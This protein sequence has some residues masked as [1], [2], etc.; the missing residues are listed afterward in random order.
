MAGINE[1][2]IPGLAGR[3]LIRFR[4]KEGAP[5]TLPLPIGGGRLPRATLSNGFRLPRGWSGPLLTPTTQPP[6]RRQDTG[7]LRTGAPAGGPPE[8]GGARRR[9]PESPPVA[10]ALA[11]PTGGAEARSEPAAGPGLLG[12]AVRPSRRSPKRPPAPGHR[13]ARASRPTQQPRP[14]PPREYGPAPAR[15]ST[16]RTALTSPRGP[17]AGGSNGPGTRGL[18]R[19]QWPDSP[20]RQRPCCRWRNSGG[21]V[22]GASGAGPRVSFYPQCPA[23]ARADPP[24]PP[25]HSCGLPVPACSRGRWCRRKT[26][27]NSQ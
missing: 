12:Q 10:S 27:E 4:G 24:P 9:D 17:R 11:S 18:Q 21:H 23:P 5:D 1:W 2:R 6:P 25:L 20:L 16:A 26:A 3:E 15:V 7:C 14:G 13:A 19:R 8:P 22:G